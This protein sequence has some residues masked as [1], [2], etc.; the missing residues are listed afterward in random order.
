MLLNCASCQYCFI[1]QADGDCLSALTSDPIV[2][3]KKIAYARSES[4]ST[5]FKQAQRS[6]KCDRKSCY[7]D[8]TAPSWLWRGRSKG[9]QESCGNTAPTAPWKLWRD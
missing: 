3:E 1:P 6:R 7:V 8:K 9:R 2:S 5:S 4:Q